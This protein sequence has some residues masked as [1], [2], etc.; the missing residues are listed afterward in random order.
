MK[1]YLQ[2]IRND[3]GFA[4]STAYITRKI[5][6]YE[7]LLVGTFPGHTLNE[8]GHQRIAYE[9]P[10][11]RAELAHRQA[12]PQRRKTDDLAPP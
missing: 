8:A 1:Y 6:A 12:L 3:L 4:G 2:M 5:A 11:Y 9:L 10:F 7:T